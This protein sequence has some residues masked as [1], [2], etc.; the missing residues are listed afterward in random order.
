[1]TVLHVSCSQAEGE[2]RRERIKG[3][4]GEEDARLTKMGVDADALKNLYLAPSPN[5]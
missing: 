2:T 3:D 5:P 4:F 1:V